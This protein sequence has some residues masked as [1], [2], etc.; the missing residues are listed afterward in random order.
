MSQR[1]LAAAAGVPQ[2]TVAT[3]ESGQRQPSVQM[4]ERLLR[5]A[6]FQLETNLVNTIRPSELL[7]KHQRE[8]TNV[9][10]RYPVARAWVFG[11]VARGD[12][13]PQSDL[14]LLVELAPGASF[15]EYVGLEDDLAAVLGCR[16]DVV[17]TK[18]LE[19]NDLFR[20]RVH[21]HLRPLEGAA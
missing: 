8:V 1:D 10:A 9:I 11:S 19:S 4:L 7:R 21:R 20:R 18:E 6:G 12:D 14:D 3:V 17:T 16:V 5:A 2:S 15:P 13:R